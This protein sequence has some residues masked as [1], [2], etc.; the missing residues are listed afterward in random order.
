MTDL[1]L[2]NQHYPGL[3]NELEKQDEDELGSQELEIERSPS[4]DPVIKIRG[5]YVH[6]KR[7]PVREGRR[8]LE[9]LEASNKE[10]PII[11]LGFGLGYAAEA[12]ALA[13]P[14]RPLVI[15]EKRRR[16]FKLA[17]EL[18]D[19]Q[20]LFTKN[21]IVF[22][23][24]GK[25]D[26]IIGALSLFNEKK[27][28]IIRNRALINLD[29][30]W[31][32]EVEKGIRSWISRNDVNSATLKRFG[33][34]WVKNLS[35]NLQNSRDRP[36]IA[37]LEGLLKTTALPVFLAAAGPSLDKTGPWIKEIHD[38]CIIVAVDTSLRFILARGIEPDFVVSLDP[39]YWNFRHLDRTFAPNTCL[40]AESAVYPPCLRL[41]KNVFLCGSHF[42][43]GRFIE[44]RLDP[45]GT[46]GTGGSVATAAWDFAKVLGAASIWIA[47]LDLSFPD[48]KTH[49]RG[50]LFEDRSHG[51][52]FR[53]SPG[54]TWSVKALRDGGPFLAKSASG[55][56]VL[57]DQRLSLY[58]AW[59][60]NRFS[61]FP[62]I[63]NFSLSGEGLAIQGLET[64]GKEA[65]FALPQRRDEINSLLGKA[66]TQINEKFN[67]GAAHRAMQYDEALKT[68]L[69]GLGDIQNTAEEAAD[70]AETFCR[71]FRRN[72]TK[73]GDEGRILGKLDSANQ[74]INASLVREIAGFLF[75]DTAEVEKNLSL[76]ESNP[77]LQHLEFSRYFYQ[78]LSEAAA[79]NLG[80]LLKIR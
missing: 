60:E 45:K 34:R 5:L 44:D 56:A 67:S 14:G 36:G 42:P 47:G 46:L 52:S 20:S 4:G 63:R 80:V 32:G 70:L 76:E 30:T 55:A 62:E 17:L 78:T 28:E 66:F 7:D 22:V 16:V 26:Q 75:P 79:Y 48:L 57:T 49:F 53:F 6:S 37:S 69:Q 18:R 31:Y 1:S 68:L 33:R 40:I 21:Q 23:L 77:L 51:E 39:Q 41:F 74:S 58:A 54:E 15:V 35:K 8:Q 13:A 24:G 73:T 12:A 64:A 71:R 3:I 43:L 2:L 9:C 72:Q 29:E 25:G 65:L 10:G 19:L 38:R 27:F 61:Q 11:I 50:A 59:F